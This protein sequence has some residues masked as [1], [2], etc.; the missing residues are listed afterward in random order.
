MSPLRIPKQDQIDALLDGS[1]YRLVREHG[2]PEFVN[3]SE[4]LDITRSELEHFFHANPGR[5]E[6][7][8]QR[9]LPRQPSA[10]GLRIENDGERYRLVTLTRGGEAVFPR[11]FDNFE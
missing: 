1:I 9:I 11:V 3:L 2:G 5:A 7:C 6:E 4:W 10:D 8:F